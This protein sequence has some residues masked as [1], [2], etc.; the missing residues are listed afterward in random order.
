MQLT[1]E[2]QNPNELQLILQYL[3]LLP[4]VKVLAPPQSNGIS[5]TQAAVETGD[6]EYRNFG[7]AKGF[8]TYTDSDFDAIPLGFEEYMPAQL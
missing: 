1:I 4:S 3:R 5:E 8:F 2:I 7:F 6:S